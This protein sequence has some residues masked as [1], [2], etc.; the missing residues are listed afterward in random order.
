[1]AR[2]IHGGSVS[3]AGISR[4]GLGWP[5][6]LY[7]FFLAFAF[8]FAFALCGFQDV[9][10]LNGCAFHLFVCVCLRLFAFVC[11]CLRLFAFVCGCLR[12][13][14]YIREVSSEVCA[15]FMFFSR[16]ACV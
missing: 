4:G 11:V 5:P 13:T 1:M 7:V 3:G 15:S 10:S 6:T 16:L 9:Q 2:W 8:A 14:V 12:L